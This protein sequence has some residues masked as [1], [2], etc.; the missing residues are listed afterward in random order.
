MVAVSEQLFEFHESVKLPRPE[1]PLTSPSDRDPSALHTGIERA[2]TIQFPQGTSGESPGGGIQ[3]V[4]NHG[5][6]QTA[7]PIP[8]VRVGVTYT[9]I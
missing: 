5:P 6:K 1:R 3:P 4:A 7:V 2:T 8:R 9:R